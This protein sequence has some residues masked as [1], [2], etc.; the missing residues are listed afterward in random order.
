MAF[1]PT[2]PE[3][4]KKNGKIEER[5][6]LAV[7]VD[8]RGVSRVHIIINGA[9]RKR[10]FP[11]SEKGTHFEVSF[12][13]GADIG[14]FMICQSAKGGVIAHQRGIKGHALTLIVRPWEAIAARRHLAVPCRILEDFGNG[15][16]VLRVPDE[17]VPYCDRVEGIAA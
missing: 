5:I 17:P 1:E 6:S 8:Q 15:G 9:A 16:L 3:A 10:Y 13:V 2:T 14:R 11:A 12:G 4:P 7:K